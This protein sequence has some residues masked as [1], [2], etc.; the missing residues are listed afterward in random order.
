MG[1]RLFL[2]DFDGVSKANRPSDAGVFAA[3]L[4]KKS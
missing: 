4:L 1:L 2:L 3:E